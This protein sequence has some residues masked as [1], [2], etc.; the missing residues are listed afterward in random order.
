M[1]SRTLAASLRYIET[2][3]PV[4]VS[5]R[6]SCGTNLCHK[7][8]SQKA[9]VLLENIAKK[10]TAEVVVSSLQKLSYLAQA[11]FTNSASWGV[12]QSRTRLFIIALDPVQ[13]DLAESISTQ[14]TIADQWASWLKEGRGRAVS[15]YVSSQ[16][17]VTPSP[18]CWNP[19]CKEISRLSLKGDFTR[20]LV[21]NSDPNLDFRLRTLNLDLDSTRLGI[22]IFESSQGQSWSFEP[23]C[24]GLMLPN[25]DSRVREFFNK[26]KHRR[27]SDAKILES[28][29]NGQS[30]PK[31]FQE[32]QAA[33][34]AV[35]ARLGEE[36]GHA[37]AATFRSVDS[38]QRRFVRSAVQRNTHKHA[39]D[40]V[41]LVRS[42][43]LG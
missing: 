7:P 15:K 25:S 17:S 16:Q 34:Q 9:Y 39:R 30:W 28:M 14:E 4:E 36:A 20:L 12:P 3:R 6:P 40:M 26:L 1:S 19:F 2:K 10:L 23:R 13:V 38:T 41:C 31:C 22:M 33:K 5:V 11:F 27:L 29:E 18:S 37:R 21:C 43:W 24:Q 32:H 35:S 42:V 8:V